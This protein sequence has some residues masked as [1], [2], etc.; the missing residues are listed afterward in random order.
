MHPTFSRWT[1]RS[2]LLAALALAAC[3]NATG[4]RDELDGRVD[5]ALSELYSTVPGTEELSRQASGV[6]V[7]PS[8]NEAGLF[9]GGSY[10]EGALVIGG[11]KVDYY[12]A[13]SASIGFQV[14]GQRYRHAIFFMTPE[15]LAKFRQTDGWEIGV[16]AE[17]AVAENG[18]SVTVTSTSVNKPVYAVVFG[19]K[20]L[21]VGAS[22]EGLKYSRIVR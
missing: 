2:M 14:G 20:G 19:Q 8:V 22:I 1:R 10:G 4:D 5:R 9:V 6:L 7:I 15:A 3:S 12:S 17:Y 11:A 16:D 21:L 18:N 13:A